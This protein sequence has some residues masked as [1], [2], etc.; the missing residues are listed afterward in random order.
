MPNLP[1]RF[2]C[3]EF[4]PGE[5]PRP[6][7]TAD[8]SVP[9][10]YIPDPGRF[11][12]VFTPLKS[13][14]TPSGPDIPG[15]GQ[16]GPRG[17]QPGR[18]GGPGPGSPGSPG[19]NNPFTPSA[20]AP[21]GQPSGGGGGGPTT[22]G[23]GY[24]K[25]QVDIIYCTDPTRTYSQS[26]LERLPIRAISRGRVP[27]S[28]EEA[29][30]DVAES[31]GYP[32][33]PAAP[34]PG[35]EDASGFC[36]PNDFATNEFWQGCVSELVSDCITEPS[37]NSVITQSSTNS[38]INV[39]RPSTSITQ[40]QSRVAGSVIQNSQS[41]SQR[42]LNSIPTKPEQ[43][44]NLNSPN[45]LR[46]SSTSSSYNERFGLFDDRF[47]FFRTNP[48]VS[49]TL[50]ANSQYLTIFKDTI[51]QEIYYFIN[52]EG[53]SSV[54]S[55]EYFDSLTH[56][57]IIISLKED[58]LI[59]LSN[60]HTLGGTRVNLDD[61]LEII[62]NHLVAGTLSEFDPNY[63]YYTYNSQVNDQIVSL[64]VEGESYLGLQIAMGL[65]EL[66][67]SS[68]DYSKQ[69]N[70]ST[71]NDLKRIRFLLEDLETN[72]PTSQLNGIESPLYLRNSGMPTEQIGGVSSYLGIGDGAGY[73]LSAQ[74]SD[75]TQAPLLTSNEL[76]SAKYIP[77][78]LRYNLLRL[79]GTDIGITLTVSSPQ[80]AN[81]F[82]STYNSS[83]DISPM[84]FKINFDTIGDI[85]NPNSVINI[86]SSSYVRIPDEEAVNHSRNYSLNV[87]KVNLDYSDPM[88]HYARD[89]SSLDLQQ[90]DFNL[91]GIDEN[92]S[93]ISKNIILRNLPAGIILTPGKGSA[94][95]PFNIKSKIAT[96]SDN[97]ITRSLNLSPSFDVNNNTITRIP[98][99][100]S[101]VYNS[102]G[103]PYFGT[104]E[105]YFDQDIH[106]N[107]FTYSPSSSIFSKSYF[108]G[109]Y[110][111]TQPSVEIREVPIESTL[112][113]LVDKLSV[114]ADVSS[115]TWWDVFRRCTANTIGRL[116]YTSPGALV[117]RLAAGW[118]NNIP[119][120]NVI[121]RE[122]MRPSGIPDGTSIPNDQIIINESDR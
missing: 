20:V 12:P 57:K 31:N 88:I 110:S 55:E 115:L 103:T 105:S 33:D 42:L 112:V 22:G 76:S 43:E 17:P 87:I 52:R 70:L 35:D 27:C 91:R 9:P 59:A 78:P 73:Y 16:G 37:N 74:Y 1:I 117:T 25:C 84:Y 75:S 94:H 114:L 71:K 119:I 121:T 96:Y 64:S 92:R 80:T 82:S 109:T 97:L 107:L 4:F 14:V 122:N 101:N 106:G 65:F 39:G 36:L 69:S 104:Y 81:E 19:T 89:T 77:P 58:L 99:E 79:L 86:L 53:A 68:P 102:I 32:F 44:L 2:P 118:R 90:D 120:Q 21:S 7:T 8:T 15:P 28:F 98:L 38:T 13:I 26:E 62:K 30:L 85:D 5:E 56:D 63:F 54:W 49:T 93:V 95:N 113:S 47:N 100:S 67:S 41:V 10:V 72:I 6:T 40:T 108:S 46:Q 18:G 24:S 11:E 23:R 51:A 50:V 83:A 66:S 3:G 45:L 116:A 48:S 60:I 29:S 61:F 34:Y 111:N